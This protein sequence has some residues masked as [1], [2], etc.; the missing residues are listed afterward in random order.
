MTELQE[1]RGL[2]T[3]PSHITCSW[4]SCQNLAR[5]ADF[6]PQPTLRT[7]TQVYQELQATVSQMRDELNERDK[8]LSALKPGHKAALWAQPRT[9]RARRFVG[10]PPA[11][12]VARCFDVRRRQQVSAG[13]ST[14]MGAADRMSSPAARA[15]FRCLLT[16]P[17]PGAPTTRP[18]GRPWASDVRRDEA[19]AFAGG[20]AARGGGADYS[21]ADGR[22]AVGARERLLG[23]VA[24]SVGNSPCS[25]VHR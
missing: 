15:L 22:R 18:D 11:L 5:Y 9:V 19:E 6:V 20:V 25:V 14:P 3:R 23:A 24:A 17:R 8:E 7:R 2:G 13:L 1:V 16:A 21:G 10:S 12:L 4:L